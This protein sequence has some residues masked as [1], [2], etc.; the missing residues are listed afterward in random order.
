MQWRME[1]VTITVDEYGK[2]IEIKQ[3]GYGD[4]EAVVR[5]N[6]EQVGILIN[7]LKEA[8]EEAERNRNI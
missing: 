6:I 7:W 8:V 3:D 2:Y 4:E 1:P 5:L